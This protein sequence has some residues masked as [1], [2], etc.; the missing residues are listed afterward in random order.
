MKEITIIGG[1]LA[2]V[3]ATWQILKRGG[4]VRLYEMKPEKFSPAHR[5]PHLAELVCSNSFKNRS[6]ENASGLLKEEMKLFDSIVMESAEKFSVPAGAALAVDRDK[7]SEY[8]T[9]KLMSQ[10]GFELLRQE[11]T[12]IPSQGIVIIAT[13][14]LTSDPLAKA[15]ENLT[16]SE[17][18]YFYDSIAPVIYADSINLKIA[19]RQSRYERGDGDYLNCPMDKKEYERFYNALIKAEL[20]PYREFEQ[21]KFFEGCLPIEE[22]AKRGF[23]T[24]CYGPMKPKGL[25]DPRTGKEP[26]AV[27]QLR[28]EDRSA[29]LYGMVGF[30]TRLK[31][32]EQERIFRMIPGLE[33]AEFARLGSMHRN[34]YINSPELLNPDLSLKKDPRLFFAGQLTG[35][36]GYLESASCGI[37]AGIYALFRAYDK[38]PIL[39]PKETII[40]S[41]LNYVSTPKSREFVPINANWGILPETEIKLRKGNR[42]KYLAKRA[43]ESLQNYLIKLQNSF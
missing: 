41:L 31:Y 13:G 11:L 8:I 3:E 27:V 15:I 33:N 5:F 19:F 38:D 37:S 1:G 14:P 23:M 26:F 32:P 35:V 24:L 2:G 22:M 21:P 42:R 28:Q 36:E 43:L 10:K 18:L 20:V 25:I 7:F 16:G 30:Q 29:E 6:I 40:G 12:E 17:H 4:K 34:T 9:E 39:I